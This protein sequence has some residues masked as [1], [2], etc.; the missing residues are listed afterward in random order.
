VTETRSKAQQ[1][2]KAAN[3]VT[4]NSPLHCFLADILVEKASAIFNISDIFVDLHKL[5]LI[6]SYFQSVYF[7]NLLFEAKGVLVMIKV[8]AEKLIHSFDLLLIKDKLDLKNAVG[9]N[10]KIALCENILYMI[11]HISSGIL[12][13]YTRLQG[14]HQIFFERQQ[15]TVH[16]QENQ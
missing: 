10:L 8:I 12:S 13:T 15:N 16:I 11:Y 9:V 4:S 6:N 7:T 1:K 2:E 3:K 5:F 14:H